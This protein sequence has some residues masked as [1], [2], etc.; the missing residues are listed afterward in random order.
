LQQRKGKGIGVP[1]IINKI[2][3]Q[4]RLVLEDPATHTAAANSITSIIARFVPGP[5]WI[6]LG[7]D[8]SRIL[9]I[10]DDRSASLPQAAKDGF[11]NA[12]TE[13]SLAVAAGRLD[14]A[15][16]AACEG[17]RE[18]V[19]SFILAKQAEHNGYDGDDA[20][21]AKFAIEETTKSTLAHGE[22]HSMQAAATAAATAAASGGVGGVVVSEDGM[23]VAMR[24]AAAW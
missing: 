6:W 21:G 10:D 20:S 1:L 3:T 11:E 9:N 17:G 4:T 12:S 7:G 23:A 22:H 19:V 18:N 24:T 8:G 5:S 16:K 13:A 2:H 14:A 15:L